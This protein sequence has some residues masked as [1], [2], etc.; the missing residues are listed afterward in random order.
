[1]MRALLEILVIIVLYYVFKTVLRSAVKAYHQD[2]SAP[3]PLEGKEMVLDPECGTYV[4]KDRALTRRVGGR[5]LF[6]CSEACAQHYE[7]KHRG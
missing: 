3:A 4:I 6:F 1:M 5:L 2:D 7:E